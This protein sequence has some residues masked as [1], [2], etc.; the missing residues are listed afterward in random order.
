MLTSKLATSE[1]LKVEPA[2]FEGRANIGRRDGKKK[3]RKRLQAD[4]GILKN[5]PLPFHSWANLYKVV[6]TFEPVNEIL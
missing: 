6:L 2:K 1:Y 5:T 3:R 4:P